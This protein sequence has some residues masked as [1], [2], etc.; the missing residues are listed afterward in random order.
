MVAWIFAGL[1]RKL[2]KKL[3]RKSKTKGNNKIKRHWAGLETLLFFFSLRIS[4]QPRWQLP[5]PSLFLY[6]MPLIFRHRTGSSFSYTD[7]SQLYL[8]PLFPWTA[9]R[10]V[11]GDC[12]PWRKEKR[13]VIATK[14][15]SGVPSHAWLGDMPRGW[16]EQPEPPHNGA[17]QKTQPEWTEKGW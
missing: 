9:V 14:G 13:K 1:R 6:R 17:A 3:W 15:Q 5:E 10:G 16:L 2:K 7:G 8:V 12:G 11:G 4:P